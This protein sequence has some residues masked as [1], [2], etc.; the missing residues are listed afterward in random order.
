VEGDNKDSRCCGASKVEEMKSTEAGRQFMRRFSSTTEEYAFRILILGRLSSI[1]FEL[2]K[3]K[4]AVGMGE[5]DGRRSMIFLGHGSGLKPNDNLFA[6][7]KLQDWRS[8]MLLA[9][10]MDATIAPSNQTPYI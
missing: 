2:K 9:Q 10:E 3:I 5:D 7:L 4:L 8:K 6:G 1:T